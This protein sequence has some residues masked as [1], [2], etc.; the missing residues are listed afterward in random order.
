MRRSLSEPL[1]YPPSS[2]SSRC[3]RDRTGSSDP[4]VFVIANAFQTC[5]FTA[6]YS[7]V[8]NFEFRIRFCHINSGILRNKGL[9]TGWEHVMS[10]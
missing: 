5:I 2:C 8:A 3:S 9:T 10:A 7:S 1:P 4:T 6:P